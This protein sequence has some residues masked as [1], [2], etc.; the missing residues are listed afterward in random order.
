MSPASQLAQYLR[1]VYPAA[2]FIIVQPMALI[3]VWWIT[4]EVCKR[5]HDR[6]MELYGPAELRRRIQDLQNAKA[7]RGRENVRL[8]ALLGAARAQIRAATV[9]QGHAI[10]ALGGVPEEDR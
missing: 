5:K 9:A 4:M 1:W 3:L 8:V 2:I 6:W 7:E 10:Q